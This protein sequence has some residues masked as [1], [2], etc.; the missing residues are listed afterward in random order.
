VYSEEPQETRGRWVVHTFCQIQ[1][2]RKGF[3]LRLDGRMVMRDREPL[4]VQGTQAMVYLNWAHFQELKEQ[5]A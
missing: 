1:H 2:E 3:Y 5:Y 4:T